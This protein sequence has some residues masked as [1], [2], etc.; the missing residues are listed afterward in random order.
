MSYALDFANEAVEDLERLLDS[1][2]LERRDPAVEAVQASLSHF[3]EHPLERPRPGGPRPF[4]H[5]NFRVG[6]VAYHWAAT[7]C[8][9]QDETRIVVTHVYRIAL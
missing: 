8:F 3:A 9:S 6:E 5:L 4:V 7:Y 2:P 1:L